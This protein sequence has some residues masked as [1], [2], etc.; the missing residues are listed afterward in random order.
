MV[1]PASCYLDIVKT[2][3]EEFDL[4]IAVITC[5]ANTR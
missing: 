1:K 4:P 2:L 5:L 3:R